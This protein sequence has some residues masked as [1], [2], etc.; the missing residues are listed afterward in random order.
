MPSTVPFSKPGIDFV[1]VNKPWSEAAK[2]KFMEL[3]QGRD[4]VCLVCDKNR[5]SGMVSVK[6]V[7]TSDQEDVLIDEVLIDMNFARS[8]DS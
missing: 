4:F 6:L 7:D 3:A 8:L 5:S 2:Y 1:K